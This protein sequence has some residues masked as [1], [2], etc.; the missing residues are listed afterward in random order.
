M[1]KVLS[2][3]DVKSK[4]VFAKMK[5]KQIFIKQAKDETKIERLDFSKQQG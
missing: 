1:G 3:I 2:F 4:T 5:I